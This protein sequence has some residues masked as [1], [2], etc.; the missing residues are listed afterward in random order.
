MMKNVNFQKLCSMNLVLM[1]KR[2]KQ[3][4]KSMLELATHEVETIIYALYDDS[5]CYLDSLKLVSKI[6]KEYEKCI[7]LD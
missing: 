1:F 2:E 5:E 7:L 6:R 4:E 3:N